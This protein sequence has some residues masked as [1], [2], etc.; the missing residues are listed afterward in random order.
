VVRKGTGRRSEGRG[1]RWGVGWVVRSSR[2]AARR[3][4]RAPL[5][6]EGEGRA[7][8]A[9]VEVAQLAQ[10]ALHEPWRRSRS[11][12]SLAHRQGQQ[13]G[14]GM[15]AT[16]TQWRDAVGGSRQVFQGYDERSRRWLRVVSRRASQLIPS[17]RS[18]VD[19]QGCHRWRNGDP[20][21]AHLQQVFHIELGMAPAA[22]LVWREQ[23]VPG[24][25][26]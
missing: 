25:L 12:R 16:P 10:Q 3:G 7:V 26:G 18:P 23:Q 11:R 1:C 17:K 24:A 15:S 19:G 22:G 21:K 4:L 8:G 20:W 6:A 13:Q 9:G 2:Q 5:L 14:G